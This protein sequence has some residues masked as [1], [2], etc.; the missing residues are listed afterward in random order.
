MTKN[1]PLIS[2]IVPV[3]NT[4]KYLSACLDSVIHQTYQNLEIILINDGSTDNS[5]SIIQDYVKKD[6]RIKV[7]NQKNQGLSGA[8]NQGLKKATGDYVTFVDSDDKIAPTMLANLIS[9]LQKTH[10]DI[11]VCSF[12]EI[13]PN[14]K[15]VHFNHN[16]LA[17]TYDTASALKAM[18]K[19]QGFMVSATMKLFPTQYFKDVK[20]PIGKLHEDVGTTF[21]LIMKASKVTFIPEELYLYIHHDDSIISQEFDNRKFDLIT[22]TDQ[23]CDDI[24]QKF[25]ELKNIT[26][27]RRIRARFSILRQ[28]PLNHQKAKSLINYLKAHKNYI[29]KNPEATTTDKIALRLALT[30]PKLFQLAYKLFK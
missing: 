25:P 16:Y 21:K 13:Y 7:I 20:F 3:Y 23:M 19:E 28:I 30:S 24:D 22:L 2:V 14:G 6:S 10:S 15:V 1:T 4:A 9:A 5:S 8:R 27:E 26:N 11:A 12:Q 18:L 29:T 17:Q